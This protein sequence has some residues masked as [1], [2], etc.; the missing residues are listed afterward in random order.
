MKNETIGWINAGA[1]IADD[2]TALIRC[3]ECQN[4]YLN[5]K[6]IRT[7]NDIELLER[8]MV[9]PSCKAWNVLRLH[10]PIGKSDK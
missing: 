10:R 6:D 8:H 3:P 1:I 2:P 4:D 9:C 7:K 5:V